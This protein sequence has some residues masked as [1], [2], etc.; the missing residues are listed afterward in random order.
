MKERKDVVDHACLFQQRLPC[1]SAQ[2]KVHPHGKDENQ[3]DKAVLAHIHIG[4][5][6]SQGIGEEKTDRRADQG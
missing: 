1:E 3:Y 5:Y 6:H 4:E 2:Q